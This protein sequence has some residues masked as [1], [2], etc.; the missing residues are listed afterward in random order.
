MVKPYVVSPLSPDH[1]A[2]LTRLM[3]EEVKEAAVFFMDVNGIIE[4]WNRGAEAKGLAKEADSPW[5]CHAC[6]SN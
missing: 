6:M 2:E 1:L 5:C 4:S 3:I